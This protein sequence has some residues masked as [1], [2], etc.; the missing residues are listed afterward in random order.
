MKVCSL[1]TISSPEICNNVFLTRE[2]LYTE[3]VFLYC[4]NPMEHRV[5]LVGSILQVFQGFMVGLE[6]KSLASQI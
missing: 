2:V 4:H 6:C 3:R 1:T 5:I